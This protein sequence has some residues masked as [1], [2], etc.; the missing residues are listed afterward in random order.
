MTPATPRPPSWTVFLTWCRRLLRSS[1]G[2]NKAH[3]WLLTRATWLIIAFVAVFVI[4]GCLIGWSR[5]YEVLIG[6]KAPAEVAAPLASWTVSIMGWLMIPAF[7]GGTV[8]YLVTRQIDARRT[9]SE[10]DVI[11][12]LRRRADPSSQRGQGQAQ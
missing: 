1:A 6:I 12:A 2:L 5:A 3:Y 8:G 11:K 9:E 4:D 7:V 10:A